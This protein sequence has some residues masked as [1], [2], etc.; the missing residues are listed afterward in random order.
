M[1][2]PD[3]FGLAGILIGLGLLIWLAFKGWSVL[4]LAPLAAMAAAL[5]SREPL[6]AHWTQTFM[7]SATGFLAQFFPLFLLG[8]LFGK[9]MEDSGSVAA[10]AD[11]M[12]RR[13][14]AERAIL[15]VVLGGALVTYGGVSLFVAFFVIAPMAQDLF[16][17]AA[18]PRRLMP[19]AIMLGTSTFTMSAMPGTPSIQNTIPM[20]FFGTTPFAAPG[21]GVLASLIMVGFGLWW[22]AREEAAAKAKGEGFGAGAPPPAERVAEDETLRERATA[23]R[24]FDPAEI[25]HGK[26]ATEHPS[27]AIAAAP[28]VVVI[29]VNLV[30]SLLVLPRLDLSFLAA[31]QWGGTSP[32]A[33]SGVWSVITA[34]SCAIVTALALNARRI[35]DLRLTMDAGVNASALPAISVASLVGFGAVVAAM[36]AFEVVRDVVL[37]IG[38]GPL[39]SLAVATNTL[40]ALTGSASGG[41]TIALDALGATYLERAAQIGLDPALLHRVAVIGSGTLD[42]LPHNGA[43]VTLLSVCGSTHGESYR[44][45]FMVGVLGAILALVAVIVLGSALGSF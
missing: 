10:I 36:P 12:T 23:A 25:A 22:L 31:P 34:L 5:F 45:I 30:L 1:S 41:L 27:I 35:P 33:V 38:G 17:S 28:I 43:V 9:L 20:P 16:R 24:E 3:L 13:L 19:A 42:S 8:A 26:T 18:I 37:G 40:A 14:G 39:V 7:R 4:L 44:D 32:A 29:L 15:A 6:L 2:V 11:F 21:L